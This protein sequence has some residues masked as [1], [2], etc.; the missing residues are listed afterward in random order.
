M[1]SF[2]FYS[3]FQMA[4]CHPVW[5][6]CLLM[7]LTSHAFVLPPN[8]ERNAPES[9]DVPRN[10]IDNTSGNGSQIEIV[11]Q[12]AANNGDIDEAQVNSQPD[13][14]TRNQSVKR[15]RPLKH[16]KWKPVRFA[17]DE[18]AEVQRRSEFYAAFAKRKNSEATTSHAMIQAVEASV[19][20][21]N[22]NYVVPGDHPKSGQEEATAHTIHKKK[23][24][25]LYR[26]ESL[27]IGSPSDRMNFKLRHKRAAGTQ[28][29]KRNYNPETMKYSSRALHNTETLTIQP[30]RTNNYGSPGSVD[31]SDFFGTGY[32][33]PSSVPSSDSF[34][35][36]HNAI[37]SIDTSDSFGNGYDGPPGSIDTSDSFGNGYGPPGSIDTSDSFGNGYDGQP[38]SIGISDSFGNDYG[39]PGSIGTSDSFG[40]GYGPPGSIDTSDSFGNGYGPPG[41]IDTSDSFGNGYDGPPGSIDTSDSFGNGYGPPGSIDTSDFFGNGYDGPP[42]SIGISD[43]FGNDYGPPGSIDTSDSFGNGYG[44][45]GSID[46]SDSLYDIYGTQPPPVDSGV[47]PPPP[48]DSGVLPPPPVNSGVLPPPPVNSGVLPPLPVDSGVLPPLPVNSGVLPPPPVNSGVLPPAPVKYGINPP[49]PVDNGYAH[50]PGTNNIVVL[51]PP[52]VMDNEVRPPAIH[53]NDV[54]LP[55]HNAAD[56]KSPSYL[57]DLD[58]PNIDSA[59]GNDY[60][61]PY[62]RNIRSPHPAKIRAPCRNVLFDNCGSIEF[63]DRHPDTLNEMYDVL[64]YLKW[65][66]REVPFV[67]QNVTNCTQPAPDKLSELKNK[68]T[69]DEWHKRPNVEEHQ[70]QMAEQEIIT[71]KIYENSPEKFGKHTEGKRHE[72]YIKRSIGIIAEIQKSAEEK[73]VEGS[74]GKVGRISEQLSPPTEK[75]ETTTEASDETSKGKLYVSILHGLHEVTTEKSDKTMAEK[76]HS[77]TDKSYRAMAQLLGNAAELSDKIIT[78]K[79]DVFTEAANEVITKKVTDIPDET[80][81]EDPYAFPELPLLPTPEPKNYSPQRSEDPCHTTGVLNFKSYC[82]YKIS[83]VIDRYQLTKDKLKY[84]VHDSCFAI[85]SDSMREDLKYDKWWLKEKAVP[86]FP[87]GDKDVEGNSN[88]TEEIVTTEDTVTTETEHS[89]AYWISSAKWEHLVTLLLLVAAP[90]LMGI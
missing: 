62:T 21:S 8:G 71:G 4:R 45:P 34:D 76:L 90:R 50:S 52:P 84:L 55:S 3:A 29:D 32:G 65:F 73:H 39:P 59:Y 26:D 46:T 30:S 88:T 53:D 35:D 33:P 38:G 77:A 70:K 47:L 42:G 56:S 83:N 51:Q 20:E 81:T 13:F 66:E 22:A 57:D 69:S 37:G 23:Q 6:S 41:S 24:I 78:E 19:A 49:I 31:A 79:L 82:V 25:S 27:S 54:H 17:S 85:Y 60:F 48:V 89:R 16:A 63:T 9:L 43:S 12:D 7:L 40:N 36:N 61:D 64:N 18:T 11:G 15:S 14:T 75:H 44:P 2:L 68:I 10:R 72:I 86:E 74:I 80:T 5:I 67:P 1:L 58:L 87:F 28:R